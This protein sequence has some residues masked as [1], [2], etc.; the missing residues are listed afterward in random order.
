MTDFVEDTADHIE[1]AVGRGEAAVADAMGQMLP[2][3]EHLQDRLYM[4]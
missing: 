1:A 3:H 2:V 4:C